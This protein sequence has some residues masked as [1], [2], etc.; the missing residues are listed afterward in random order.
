MEYVCISPTYQTYVG[1]FPLQTRT[2]KVAF[3]LSPPPPTSDPRSTKTEAR[4][5]LSLSP[6]LASLLAGY[7]DALLRRLSTSS[8][9]SAFLSEL[10]IFAQRALR[11]SREGGGYGDHAHPGA[12][13]G[14]AEFYT[15]VVAELD[16]VGWDM[17]LNLDAR[18]GK[19]TLGV[20][21]ESG[22]SHV[23]SL[24]L[25]SGPGGG[26]DVEASA[27]VPVD[28]VVPGDAF[29]LDALVTAFRGQLTPYLPFWDMMDAFDGSVHV[30]EPSA[31]HPGSFS[32]RIALGGHC[33]LKLEF[34]PLLPGNLPRCSFLGAPVRIQPLETALVANA[35]AWSTDLSI[36]LSTKI[37][38]LLATQLPGPPPSSSSSS[39]SS[40][41]T[42]T[43][44][45]PHPV[46]S[47]GGVECGIC[48]AYALSSGET[49]DTSCENGTCGRAY[50][51]SCLV[52]WM[53]SLPTVRQYFNTLF[54]TCPYCQQSMVVDASSLQ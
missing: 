50:H 13:K 1:F 18:K 33:S 54:G 52:D 23:L 36:P 6:R 47:G 39:S 4:A 29:D 7:E 37:E 41:S 28:I 2:E 12:G 32:R 17:L 49:P 43:S 8:T 3:S 25:H 34:D 31:P 9:P 46:E 11:G 5:R 53:R 26:W 35:P 21:D 45:H 30:L 40:S 14:A 20:Q 38:S 15:R 24:A 48:Y 51:L 16:K 27:D 10:Q 44:N 19:L 22:R 42:S